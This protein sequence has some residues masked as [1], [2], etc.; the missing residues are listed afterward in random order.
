MVVLHDDGN[1]V[2]GATSNPVNLRDPTTAGFQLSTN[3]YYR[4]PAAQAWLHNG[5]SYSFSGWQQ[6]TGVGA[7]DHAQ[8]DDPTEPRVFARPNR[9]Q[10]GR[11]NIIIYNWSRQAAVLVDLAGVVRVGDH[12]DVRNAQDPSSI[13]SGCSQTHSP[14]SV[15]RV[16]RSSTP[17]IPIATP[18]LSPRNGMGFGFAEPGCKIICA[19]P[20]LAPSN[21]S[22]RAMTKSVKRSFDRSSTSNTI[23]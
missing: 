7:T 11:A 12:Y 8:A 9:Y 2:F 15:A 19:H 21:A 20:C 6:A 1:S 23:K 22:D 4:D 17:S 10:A 14:P 13:Q 5:A 3:Q 18:L 16:C